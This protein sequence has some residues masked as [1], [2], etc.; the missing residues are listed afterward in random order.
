[1]KIWKALGEQRRLRHPQGQYLSA[2]VVERFGA[3]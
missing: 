1:M 2:I 3:A